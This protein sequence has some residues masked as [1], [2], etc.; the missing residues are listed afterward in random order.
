MYICFFKTPN[1]LVFAFQV[2]GNSCMLSSSFV[3]YFFLS[4]ENFA[5]S[6]N[7]IINF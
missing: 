3:I 2:L 6:K 1:P 4:R 5:L 7:C